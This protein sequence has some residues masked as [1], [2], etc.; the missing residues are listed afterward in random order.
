MLRGRPHFHKVDGTKA[1]ANSGCTIALIA[2]G[3]DNLKILRESGLGVVLVEDKKKYLFDREGEE[4]LE[5]II[6]CVGKDH[7]KITV[8]R[9]GEKVGHLYN[10]SWEEAHKIK[11]MIEAG[12]LK[13]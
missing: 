5:V 4:N 11:A 12:E 1:K 10:T 2:Y 3:D 7:Y 6:E 13:V 9:D 8:M